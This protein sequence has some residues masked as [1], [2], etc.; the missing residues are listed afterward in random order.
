MDKTLYVSDLDGTLLTPREDLSPFTIRV[1]NRLV[2]QGVAFTYATA[3]SQHSADVVTRGLT[4][5]L[6]VIIYNGAFI[7][8]GERRV[9]HRTSAQTINFK[10]AQ[11][12]VREHKGY[13][14]KCA[15]CGITDADDPNMEFRYCSKCSGYY[16]YCMDHINNHVHIQ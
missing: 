6:P 5:S 12:Q 7:R 16:C 4:K 2:E 3:R 9:R 8:R 14:H 11:K 1:L 10:K 13:L 15:V